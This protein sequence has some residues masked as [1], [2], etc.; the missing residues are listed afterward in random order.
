MV[1]SY[2]YHKGLL[3]NS[4]IS[5]DTDY[6]VNIRGLNDVMQQVMTRKS[7]CCFLLGQMSMVVFHP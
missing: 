3:V 2:Y 7:Q 1:Q 5:Q 4:M 6:A